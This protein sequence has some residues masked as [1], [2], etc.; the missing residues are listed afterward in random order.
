VGAPI[1]IDGMHASQVGRLSALPPEWR[2]EALRLLSASSRAAS[3]AGRAPPA[4]HLGTAP[5]GPMTARSLEGVAA[6][7]QQVEGGGAEQQLSF[8]WLEHGSVGRLLCGSAA[9]A[10]GGGGGDGSAATTPTTPPTSLTVDLAKVGAA[11]LTELEVWLA[12]LTRRGAAVGQ[13]GRGLE[14]EGEGAAADAEGHGSRSRRRRRRAVPRES[15]GRWGHTLPADWLRLGRERPLDTP[16]TATAQ[17]QRWRDFVGGDGGLRGGGV[18][19]L[20]QIYG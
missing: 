1:D 9:A 4:E 6:R 7:E 5:L 12:Q 8:P 2:H 11:Q 16:A 14:G 15:R 18:R 17:V 3:A 20:A 10:R 13:R 19:E